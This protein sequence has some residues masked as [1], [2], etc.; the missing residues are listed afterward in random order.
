MTSKLAKNSSSKTS[1]VPLAEHMIVTLFEELVEHAW[2]EK[3]FRA[4]QERH[5]LAPRKPLGTRLFET[6]A[7]LS[8]SIAFEGA[9]LHRNSQTKKTEVFL[10][11]REPHESFAGQWHCPGVVFHPGEFPKDVLQRL[12]KREFKGAVKTDGK[13]LGDH[14]VEDPRGWFLSRVY[15]LTTT[16]KKLNPA[17]QWWPVG[18]LPKNTIKFHRDHVIKTAVKAFEKK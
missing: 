8:I 14:F 13:C 15:L 1:R 11:L 3:D 5:E 17:G 7:R 4:F 18:A 6:I 2:S 12:A 9:L 16:S 10:L